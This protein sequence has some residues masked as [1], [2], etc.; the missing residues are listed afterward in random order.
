MNEFARN[1][2]TEQRKRMTAGL[3]QYLEQNVYE[4]LSDEE[5]A[6]L[7]S[8]VL[9]SI[10][11]YHDVCLDMMKAVVPTD[12]VVNEEALV[13]IRSMHSMIAEDY[14]EELESDGVVH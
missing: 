10:A 2:L 4:H 6:K 7:R 5:R 12:T 14:R 8:K 13:L 9:S 11:A 1:L 3:M